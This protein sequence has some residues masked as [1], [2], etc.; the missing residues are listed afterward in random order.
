MQKTF[1]CALLVFVALVSGAA[2]AQIIKMPPVAMTVADCRAGD[3]WRTV[4]GISKCQPKQPPDTCENHGLYSTNQGSGST[5][6][7]GVGTCYYPYTPP[8]PTCL[9]DYAHAVIVGDYGN[10]SADGGC[11]GTALQVKWGGNGFQYVWF[12]YWPGIHTTFDMPQIE[13][14]VQN[15]LAQS[16]GYYRGTLMSA[17]GGN[18]NS[19]PTYAWQ[20]CHP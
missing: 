15:S 12:A 2:K 19:S 16:G 8:P 13:Q 5:F 17:G 14:L 9:Y 11:D 7:P 1:A 18:G 10:C 20:V 4:N 3:E 6:V